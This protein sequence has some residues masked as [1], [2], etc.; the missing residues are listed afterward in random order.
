MTQTIADI[1]KR[2]AHID[3][4]DFAVLERSLRS[5]TRKG[6]Q[7][8]LAV[9]RRRLEAEIAEA[10]R[11]RE[12]YEFEESLASGQLLVGLDEVGRGPLAGPLAVGAVILSRDTMIP[13]LN[14]SKKLS[15]AQRESLA[16]EIKAQ[17]RAWTVEYIEAEEI[18]AAGISLCLRMAFS[19]AVRK[20]E[21]SGLVPEVVLLDGNPL[22]FDARERN[23][24]KGDGRCASIAAASIVAKVERDHLMQDYAKRSPHY[25]FEKSKGY[26]SPEHIEAIRVHGL[27]PLH[28]KTFCSSFLQERLF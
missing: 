9:C 12:M 15:A 1:K 14:D 25:G 27:C 21:A 16:K 4:S 24:I 13:G 17:A 11:L 23:V 5:D 18:D 8:A 7:E 26:A 22:G 28:R 19:R 6:I 10:N 2:L 3:A 20:I